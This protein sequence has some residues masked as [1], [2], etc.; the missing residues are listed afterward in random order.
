MNPLDGGLASADDGAR[1][2]DSSDKIL[3]RADECCGE[4]EYQEMFEAAQCS[5]N[6]VPN[7]EWVF[8]VSDLLALFF[9]VLVTGDTMSI[10]MKQCKLFCIASMV[11]IIY[12]E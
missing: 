5:I 6:A 4:A 11:C 3:R 9:C 1:S 12:K 8:I 7:V 10:T 2:I